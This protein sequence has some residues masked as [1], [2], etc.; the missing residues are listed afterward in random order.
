MIVAGGGGGSGGGSGGYS[1]GAG[2]GGGGSTGG[3]GSAGS[4][5]SDRYCAGK[6]GGGGSQ[7]AGGSGGVGCG[8][9]SGNG[10]SV[11]DGGTGGEPYYGGPGGGGGAAAIMA[12][13]VEGVAPQATARTTAAVE[14]AAEAAA[15]HMWAS[16]RRTRMSGKAGRT[17]SAT[18]SSSSVGSDMKVAIGARAALSL[19]VAAMLVGCGADGSSSGRPATVP[20]AARH[21]RLS[22]WR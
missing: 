4:G 1:G 3:S 14:A 15:H 22:W 9:D 12:V 8:D 17:R 10:G 13:A 18:A 7:S 16:A 5:S 11:G 6:G 21:D 2:G 20:A 19:G